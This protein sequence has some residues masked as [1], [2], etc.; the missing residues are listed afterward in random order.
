MLGDEFIKA[1]GTIFDAKDS[2]IGLGLPPSD[3]IRNME[4]ASRRIDG[5]T[6][7]DR[8]YGLK[9]LWCLGSLGNR[10]AAL[11]YATTIE[12][13]I[14][15]TIMPEAQERHYQAVASNWRRIVDSTVDLAA[16]MRNPMPVPPVLVQ[17]PQPAQS[18]GIANEPDPRPGFVVLPKIGD[19]LSIE[20]RNL[21]VRFAAILKKKVP[22]R[23][24]TPTA[25]AIGEAI[26]TQ[27]PWANGAAEIIERSF[28]IIRDTGSERTFSK[29][30]IFVGEPGTGKTSLAIFLARI[31]GR[32]WV[33]LPA[34]G[35]ADSATLAATPRGWSNFR[36]SLPAQAM[37][38][39]ISCDPCV[40][41]DELDKASRIGAQ[42]GSVMG[43]LMGMTDNPS[44]YYDTA[45][46]ANLDLSHTLF[47]AT[48]NTL[49]PI[50]EALLDRFTIV[51]VDRPSTEHFDMVLATMRR[52]TADR[53]D[54]PVES[55]P[56]LDHDEYGALKTFFSENR[57]SLRKF[58]EAYE[59]ALNSALQRQRAM[60]M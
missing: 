5:E 57:G 27:Y 42:N 41:V 18:F 25:G 20:G 55:L 50:N 46:M 52:D 38:E 48:A 47:M 19:P 35:T 36:T 59:V 40:I 10:Q 49:A 26:A 9:A 21:A 54:V 31:L 2:L 44:C 7:D 33:R 39:S 16:M 53:L 8:I 12:H 45:L 24:F 11:L 15:G 30:L 17:Q 34:A 23:S 58:S 60:M 6:L 13:H 56:T 43:A 29:P 22:R 1:P 32:H 3:S 28:T 4:I 51:P 37:L 14:E